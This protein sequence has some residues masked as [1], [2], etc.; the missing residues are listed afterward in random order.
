MSIEFGSLTLGFAFI[1]IY[2]VIMMFKW[3]FCILSQK[4]T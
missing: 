1:V 3:H 2:N 4:Y